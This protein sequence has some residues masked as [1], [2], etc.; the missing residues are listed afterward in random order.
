MALLLP[1]RH[2]RRTDSSASIQPGRGH[3]T[4]ASATFSRTLQRTGGLLKRQF[5]L[6]PI[7]GVIL[8][9]LVALSVHSAIESTMRDNLKSELQTLLNVEVA[10]VET[11]L[12]SQES[13]VESLANQVEV[14][15]LTREMLQAQ[16][17]SLIEES[18]KPVGDMEQ[19]RRSFA[20]LVAPAMNAHDYVG[21]MV[22]SQSGV[23]MA[24]SEVELV[25][26]GQMAPFRD[27]LTKVL[28][29]EPIVSVPYPSLAAVTDGRG[30]LRTGVPT[31]FCAAPI[32]DDNF[33][34][35]GVLAM[36]IRPE[37]EFTRI[38]QLGRIGD[39]GETYAFDANGNMI[40][41]SRFD[42]DLILLGLLPDKPDS[43]SLLNLQ[44][45]DPGVNM[46]RGER[47][48]VRRT[49]LPLTRMAES[50]ISG[51]SSID[52]DGYNDY[53]G[54]PV[55]GAWK[56]LSR[57]GFGIA[58]ETD[59]AEAYR[60]LTILKITFW[61]LMGLLILCSVGLLIFAIVA[62]KLQRE[63]R[64]AAI[65]AKQLG[66]YKLEDKLGEGAMG[67]VYRGQHAMLR[68]PTAI[69]LLDAD[70]VN[71][72]TIA[73]FEREV[74]TTSR[75]NHPNTIAIYD[76]GR[77][78][79]GIFYY[80][81]EYLDGINLQH[82]V[83]QY[84]PMNPARTIYIL[85]QI[86]GSLYEAHS[87]G[88]VHRDVKPANIMLNHRG[89]EADVVK[90]LDFGLVK[91]RDENAAGDDQLAGTPLYMSPEA[92]QMPGSVDPCS[93][94][95][96]VGAVGYFM[97]T[98]RPVF[99]ANTFAELCRKQ[100]SETPK[101]PTTFNQEIPEDLESI[102]LSCLEKDRSRRPQTARDLSRQL[103]HC[104]IANAWDSDAADRWWTRHARGDSSHSTAIHGLGATA[105]SGGGS[106]ATG[107]HTLAATM[108]QD[109]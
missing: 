3:L 80:A 8:L 92:I 106:T 103:M 20:R 105:V 73:R 42:E 76:F 14:R 90:V 5:W 22:L 78:P 91:A 37:R 13:N 26:K 65:E 81:M 94:L 49:E 17:D 9:S 53:R 66:Q 23:I 67:V 6:W 85:R 51:Q 41:N 99:Q 32:R 82:L 39:S 60:P 10:M 87:Q 72:T 59:V 86:C 93:D 68:R 2:A 74:Q 54:V 47:P 44:V 102:I 55:V 107:S 28:D 61:S 34:V 84:G 45:R 89:G 18:T 25:D 98:G 96:A 108:Q 11:W 95:Y 109:L 43:S 57:Y 27:W 71:Q 77:T 12:A 79:E 101:P 104:A 88:L 70:K 4:W 50:A 63:A 29:G 1:K 97:L 36:R 83:D 52:L 30:N 46:T 15:S 38:L 56:W 75:L 31:M 24:S 48:T 58:T 62:A 100:V 69:K 35:I 21:Y 19:L 33:Q 64:L 40:S 16:G 7:A